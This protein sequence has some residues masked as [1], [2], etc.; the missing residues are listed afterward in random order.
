MEQQDVFFECENCGNLITD[1]WLCG[2]GNN[3]DESWTVYAGHCDQ[4][5]EDYEHRLMDA[6]EGEYRPECPFC[7]DT[8]EIVDTDTGH[9]HACGHC[10]PPY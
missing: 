6:D 7:D 4:C 9:S 3:G 1:T 5:D 8:G 2:A 10:N